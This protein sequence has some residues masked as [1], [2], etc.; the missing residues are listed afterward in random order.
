MSAAFDCVDHDLLLLR[1]EKTFG[2]TGSVLDWL[3]SFVVGRTQ[4]VAHNGQP[5]ASQSVQCGVP[6][7]SVLG[8]LLFVLYT[9]K[10]HNVVAEHGLRLHQYADDCQ[11]YATTLA[12][13][14]AAAVDAV[15]RCI[16][17]INTWLG[18]SRL[19]LNPSKTQIMW[20][21]S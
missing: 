10:L 6:Q 21:G 7:G 9:A 8:P 18:V 17:D 11:V 16:A 1:L 15:A 20:V 13:N 12:D 5:S 19:R 2:L 4:Q 14:A 3:R